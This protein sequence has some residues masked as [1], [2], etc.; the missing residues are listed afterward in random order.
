MVFGGLPRNET[1]IVADSAPSNDV[2]DSFNFWNWST[3]NTASGFLQLAIELPF[4]E[5]LGEIYP[6]LAQSWEYN[7]DG[8]QM[9][10]TITEGVNWNDGT[11][12]AMDDWLFTLQYARDYAA[13]GLSFSQFLTGVEWHAQGTNEIVF[14]FPQ[15]NFR[16]HQNFIGDVGVGFTPVPRHVWEGQDP[17]T[18]NNPNAVG[19]GPYNLV[20]CN[21]D[22]RVCIWE[23]RDDYWNEE[24]MPAPR[25]QVWMRAPEPDV[26]IF[27]WA[28]N[29][30]TA[31]VGFLRALLGVLTPNVP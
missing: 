22:T 14:E 17:T 31:T 16:F 28:H 15:P 5:W 2:W 7:E 23:R 10:L 24:A 19:S 13:Q 4:L 3:Y 25:Y 1:L 20:S 6:W 21:P 8:T 26:A 18:F 9:T 27:E 11:P 30:R 12:L 29:F